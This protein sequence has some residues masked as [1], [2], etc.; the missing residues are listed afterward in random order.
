MTKIEFYTAAADSTTLDDIEA[1]ESLL[2][3]CFDGLT[4]TE[5]YGRYKRQLPEETFVYTI[6]S[7]T[8][9]DIEV[10]KSLAIQI[11]CQFQQES[12]LWFMTTGEGGF[13]A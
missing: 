1:V 4:V 6:L 7:P 8:P 2:I 13:S 12:V 5:G 10:C 9:V 3:N 11:A